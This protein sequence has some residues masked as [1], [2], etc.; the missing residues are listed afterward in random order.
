MTE[1]PDDV[2]ELAAR[3]Y[4]DFDGGFFDSMRHALSLPEVRAALA[5]SPVPP[6]DGVTAQSALSHCLNGVRPYDRAATI[7]KALAGHGYVIVPALVPVVSQAER[8]ARVQVAAMVECDDRWRKW[9]AQTE[10][11][12]A[13]FV[14]AAQALIDDGTIPPEPE[15]DV[16]EML[17]LSRGWSGDSSFACAVRGAIADGWTVTPPPVGTEKGGE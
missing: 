8:L 13:S 9:E 15:P 6:Q 16:A 3:E 11:D 7:I 4:C 14:A 17:A 5:P 2:V 10:R 1:I 12:K